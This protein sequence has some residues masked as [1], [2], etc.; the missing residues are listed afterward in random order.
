MVREVFGFRFKGLAN[1]NLFGKGWVAIKAISKM[2]TT[3]N[4]RE[5][6]M[7]LE[8]FTNHKTKRTNIKLVLNKNCAIT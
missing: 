4:L 7:K 6:N 1:V 3:S 8:T 5:I 2:P